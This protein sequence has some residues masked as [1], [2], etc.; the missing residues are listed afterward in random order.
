MTRMPVVTIRLDDKT[1]DALKKIGA[2]L[3]RP[4]GYLLRKAAEEYVEREKA[5]VR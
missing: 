3:D 4:I 2:R 1:L 5:G